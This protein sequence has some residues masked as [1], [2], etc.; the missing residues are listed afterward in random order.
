[1]L[2]RSA[3]TDVIGEDESKETEA[4]RQGVGTSATTPTHQLPSQTRLGDTAPSASKMAGINRVSQYDS[5]NDADDEAL[6][7]KITGS[8]FAPIYSSS[9]SSLSSPSPS[10]SFSSSP[11]GPFASATRGKAKENAGQDVGTKGGSRSKEN[12]FISRLKAFSSA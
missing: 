4:L 8:P 10:S 12:V 7:R 6:D 1:M 5:G 3:D 9:P 2:R 11:V